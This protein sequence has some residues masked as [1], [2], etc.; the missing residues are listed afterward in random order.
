MLIDATIRLH[1]LRVLLRRLEDDD[2]RLITE[3]ASLV[4]NPLWHTYWKARLRTNPGLA[5]ASHKQHNAPTSQKPNVTR[6][7]LSLASTWNDS[8]SDV[9][10][11]DRKHN[12]VTNTSISKGAAQL[13]IRARRYWMEHEHLIFL[14]PCL[15]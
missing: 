8:P 15:A 14:F 4:Q 9:K 1:D 13:V 11:C 10:I 6:V 2:E 7:A 12:G 5:N 3:T